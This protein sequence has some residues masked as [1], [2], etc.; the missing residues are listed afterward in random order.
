M[1]ISS[2]CYLK[3]SGKMKGISKLNTKNG[4]LCK[5]T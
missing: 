3:L 5:S 4:K 1:K 2:I